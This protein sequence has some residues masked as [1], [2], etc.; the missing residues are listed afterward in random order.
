MPHR[1][2]ARTSNRLHRVPCKAIIG[3]DV[4]GA[5]DENKSCEHAIRQARSHGMATLL[6]GFRKAEH[7]AH[8][9]DRDSVD[10]LLQCLPQ[11][12]GLPLDTQTTTT[13]LALERNI[14]SP[15]SH[16]QHEPDIGLVETTS[17]IPPAIASFVNAKDEVPRWL[18]TWDEDVAVHIS[19]RRALPVGRKTTDTAPRIRCPRTG[20]LGTDENRVTKPTRL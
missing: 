16:P 20:H 10:I 17:L 14:A 3:L 1:L 13:S 8:P 15:G 2:Y 11:Q 12:M 4:R 5:K 9:A 19:D 18:G 7:P 6:T